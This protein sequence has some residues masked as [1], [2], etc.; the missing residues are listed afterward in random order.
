MN[1]IKSPL[2]DQKTAAAYLG[3]TVASMN[4]L[5]AQNKLSIPFVRFGRRIKY[6]R[7]DL[8]AWIEQNR[9]VP[10]QKP[11]K[12][13]SMRRDLCFPWLFSPHRPRKQKHLC[14]KY[15][16]LDRKFGFDHN[17]SQ[18][19]D[20]K[21]DERAD[22]RRHPVPVR[23]FQHATGNTN[24]ALPPVPPDISDA[25]QTADWPPLAQDVRTIFSGSGR[26]RIWPIRQH[27][28]TLYPCLPG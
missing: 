6:Q 2:L 21:L 14:K 4:S 16:Q 28:R 22:Q 26:S 12:S 11:F 8:D 7:A 27:A 9:V 1:D 18:E 19:R 3:T 25:V 5:R 20:C 23:S 15:A 10:T 17:E 13:S 24:R